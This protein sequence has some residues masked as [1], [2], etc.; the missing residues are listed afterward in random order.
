MTDLI[1]VE[2]YKPCEDLSYAPQS[3]STNS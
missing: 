2:L 3:H 1:Y